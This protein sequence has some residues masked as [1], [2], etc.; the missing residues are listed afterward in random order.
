LHRRSPTLHP[1]H[2][3]GPLGLTTLLN[4]IWVIRDRCGRDTTSAR[5]PHIS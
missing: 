4:A 1:H 3:L 5:I 2:P